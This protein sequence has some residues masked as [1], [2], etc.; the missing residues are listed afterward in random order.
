MKEIKY[1]CLM[2]QNETKT[3][4][5]IIRPDCA[6][7]VSSETDEEG[8]YLHGWR[9]KVFELHVVEEMV[10]ERNNRRLILTQESNEEESNGDLYFQEDN[11][12]PRL[13]TV[14]DAR[15]LI[16]SG[17]FKREIA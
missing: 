13:C 9:I 3:I 4:I 17:I 12:E 1:P 16:K 8:H 2:E 11:G 5:L 15:R 14:E 6:V 10:F 7:V